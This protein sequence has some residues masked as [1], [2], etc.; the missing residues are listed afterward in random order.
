MLASALNGAALVAHHSRRGGGRQTA[1]GSTR[2]VVRQAQQVV[3]RILLFGQWPNSGHSSGT[4]VTGGLTCSQPGSCNETG[5]SLL[6]YLA[7]LPVGFTLPPTSP[8]GRWALTPP[9]HPYGPR[10]K[11]GVRGVFSVALSLGSLPVGVTHHRALRSSDFPRRARKRTPRPLPLLLLAG[12]L[13][14]YTNAPAC[15]PPYEAEW[16]GESWIR[17]LL[18]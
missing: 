10:A 16:L 3:S 18:S 7:L 13:T 8:P 6:P 9:F 17:Q 11:R 1:G 15:A 5:P 4:T 14:L 2:Q 12:R